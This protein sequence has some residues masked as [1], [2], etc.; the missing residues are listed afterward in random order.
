MKQ[1]INCPLLLDPLEHHFVSPSTMTSSTMK[2]GRSS[3]LA[4]G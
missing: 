2:I 1:E 3:A 4:S